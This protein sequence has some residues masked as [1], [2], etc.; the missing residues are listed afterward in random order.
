M[1]IEER[2]KKQEVEAELQYRLELQKQREAK[3]LNSEK[4]KE[5]ERLYNQKLK[6]RAEAE[7]NLVK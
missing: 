5:H 2:L 3:L 7:K 6:A 1:K 4:L